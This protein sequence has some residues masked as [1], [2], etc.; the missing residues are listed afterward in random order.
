MLSER[1]AEIELTKNKIKMKLKILVR[2]L[3]NFMT[4]QFAGFG[5][6]AN[7]KSKACAKP[8]IAN[9]KAATARILA[10]LERK[11]KNKKELNEKSAT[12]SCS[13]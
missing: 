2:L 1:C 10:V 7:V 3:I 12:I 4:S 9:E 8:R 5:Y 11:G 6:P 13:R